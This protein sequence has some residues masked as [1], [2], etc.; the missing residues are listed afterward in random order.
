VYEITQGIG[1]QYDR[2]ME[3]EIWTNPAA[4]MKTIDGKKKAYNLFKLIQ[5][6]A[7]VT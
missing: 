4:H 3:L 2:D 6:V 1:T 5:T 7:R